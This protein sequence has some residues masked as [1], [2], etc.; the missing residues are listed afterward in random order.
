[1]PIAS[2]A[3]C[4]STYGPTFNGKNFCAGA[5]DKNICAGDSG[6]PLVCKESDG[7]YYQ[8]GIM[9]ATQGDCHVPNALFTK[10]S[11]FLPWINGKTVG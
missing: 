6:G 5:V 11:S 9:S 3:T 1:M 8:Y 7:R 10:V 4:Q 2:D